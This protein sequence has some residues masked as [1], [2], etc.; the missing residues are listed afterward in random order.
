MACTGK[1]QQ[2]FPTGEIGSKANFAMQKSLAVHVGC[3]SR[4]PDSTLPRHAGFSQERPSA[5][6]DAHLLLPVG[7]ST[8]T[9]DAP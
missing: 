1:L 6:P 2:G 9:H 8:A 7:L 4:A 3:G 5:R